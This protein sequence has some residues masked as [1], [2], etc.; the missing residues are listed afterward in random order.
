MLESAMV[1]VTKL[2]LIVQL[3]TKS[4]R[5]SNPIPDCVT[6]LPLEIMPDSLSAQKQ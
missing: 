3:S 2:Q 6:D 5:S 4:G 1:L